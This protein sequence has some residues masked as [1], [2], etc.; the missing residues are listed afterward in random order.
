MQTVNLR[1]VGGSV[2]LSIPKPLLAALSL[3]ANQAVGV[4][5]SDGRIIVEPRPKPRYAL[6]ELVALCDANAPLTPEDRAWLDDQ[7]VGVEAI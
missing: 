7:P 5:V 4:S 3:K 6:D 1:N 2:M